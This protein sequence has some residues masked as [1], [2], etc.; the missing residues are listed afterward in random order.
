MQHARD[1]LQQYAPKLLESMQL[2]DMHVQGLNGVVGTPVHYTDAAFRYDDAF[3]APRPP[4]I[5]FP[6]NAEMTFGDVY[7][8]NTFY[9]A[10]CAQVRREQA[11]LRIDVLQVGDR[12]LN[13]YPDEFPFSREKGPQ[14]ATIGSNWVK[15]GLKTSDGC[16]VHTHVASD[17]ATLLK[18][19]VGTFCG[20]NVC[21]PDLIRAVIGLLRDHAPVMLIDQM[22]VVHDACMCY[23]LNMLFEYQ[24]LN[25]RWLKRF[26]ADRGNSLISGDL[27]HNDMRPPPGSVM[28]GAE[29]TP[30]SD[31]ALFSA[32]T[33]SLGELT[34][35]VMKMAIGR[36]TQGN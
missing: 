18:C 11:E 34:G 31:S 13:V 35:Q 27:M 17:F 28:F 19:L 30:T 33:W 26:P 16:V 32:K 6:P 3:K 8:Y 22:L 25:A 15:Y 20:A 29:A 1:I 24:V 7:T 9:E 2:T 4:A 23:A 21:R 10:A 12:R 5:E 36:D 14:Q